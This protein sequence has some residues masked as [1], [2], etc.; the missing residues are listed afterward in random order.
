MMRGVLMVLEE[1]L[2]NKSRIIIEV[3]TSFKPQICEGEDFRQ[4]I[5]RRFHNAVFEWFEKQ[6]TDNEDFEQEIMEKV[7]E[8]TLPE[9]TLEFSDLG[10][11]CL[12]L[13]QEDVEIKQKDL[14]EEQVKYHLAKKEIS[15]PKEQT[16]LV[17]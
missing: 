2:P 1:R 17:T 11:V 9:K 7:Q 3:Q 6:A 5:I 4:D 13:H 10:E 15:L 12:S 14:T 8:D 16:K